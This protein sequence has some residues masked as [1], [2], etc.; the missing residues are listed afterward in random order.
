MKITSLTDK[1]KEKLMNEMVMLPVYESIHLN[2]E[3]EL[4]GKLVDYKEIPKYMLKE[5]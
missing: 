2:D 5:D 1:R 4:V 3:G